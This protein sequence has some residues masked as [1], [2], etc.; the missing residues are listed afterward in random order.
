VSK[1]LPLE[2]LSTSERPPKI[3]KNISE[4]EK[5]A[6]RFLIPKHRELGIRLEEFEDIYG[7]EEIERDLRSIEKKR[8]KMD[9]LDSALYKRAQLLEAILAEQIELSDWFGEKVMT[10]VPSE[11]DDLFNGIDLTAEFEKEGSYQYMAMG[12]DVTSSA[13][14]VRKKLEIIKQHIKDETLTQMKYFKSERNDIQGRFGKIPQLLIGADART[15]NELSDLWLTVHKSRHSGKDLNRSELEELK[16]KA[17]EAQ[18]KLANHRTAML[19]LEEL[20]EQLNIF[21]Q[22]AEKNNSLETA[23]KYRN[24]LKLVEKAIQTKHVSLAEQKYN[25]SD[26]VYKSIKNELGGF[27][28][29]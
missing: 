28:A 4:V 8:A 1:E 21:A 6:Y 3:E 22:F 25:E 2:T 29:E 23:E 11:Y 10:I 15:I 20:R 7:P 9:G 26:D 13:N 12:I 5:E 27:L 19:I 16:Q 17:K 18:E 24:L 14:P